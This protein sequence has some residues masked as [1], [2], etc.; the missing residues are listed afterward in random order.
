M[1]SYVAEVTKDPDSTIDYKFDWSLWLAET[2]TTTDTISTSAW[3][4]SGDDS[5]LTSSSESSTTTTA[6]IW[7]AA[8]TA[9]ETYQVTNRIV[10]AGGRTADRTMMVTVQER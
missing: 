7:L 3:T 1:S 4:I 8:G 6:T 9:K 10:T 2:T 5:V